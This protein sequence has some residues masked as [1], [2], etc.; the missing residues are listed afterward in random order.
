MLICGC[1]FGSTFLLIAQMRFAFDVAWFATCVFQ[2]KRRIAVQ[3]FS[4]K[5]ILVF[6]KQPQTWMLA[7]NRQP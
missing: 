2:L 5:T 6:H 1:I 3:L 7:V 4:L